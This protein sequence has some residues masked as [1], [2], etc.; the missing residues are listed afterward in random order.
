MS[1][2]EPVSAA[3]MTTTVGDQVALTARPPLRPGEAVVEVRVPSRPPTTGE[4]T[5]WVVGFDPFSKPSEEFAHQKL[6]DPCPVL[7]GRPAELNSEQV[8]EL[9]AGKSRVTL[10]GL[11]NR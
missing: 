1:P 6:R 7:E 8:V 9:G 3:V 11:S 2:P 4:D 10:S 5:A